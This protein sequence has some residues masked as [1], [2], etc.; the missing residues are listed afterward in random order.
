MMP[1]CLYRGAGGNR[2]LVQTGKPYAF[3]ML[4]LAFGFRVQTRPKLP[5]YTLSSKK[6]TDCARPQAAISDFAAPLDRN[7][8][9]RQ[10]PSDVPFQHLVPK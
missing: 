1:G 8:S 6:F 9:E 2:T 5:I 4:I 3:Y 7:A 10:L